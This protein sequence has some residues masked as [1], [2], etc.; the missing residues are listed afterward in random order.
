MKFLIDNN[1][2]EVHRRLAEYPQFVMGQLRTPR[3]KTSFA[4]GRTFAIDNGAFIGFAERKFR[5]LLE[6][7]RPERDACLFVVAPDIPMNARRTL[8]C[9]D[10]WGDEL[11]GWPIALAAQNGQEDLSIPWK[12]ID[13][14]FIGGDDRF[15]DSQS[16]LDIC[17]AGRILGKHVHVGRV[18][19]ITRF[20]FFASHADTCDG[21]GAS[22]FDWMIDAI[23]DGENDDRPLLVTP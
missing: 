14:I 20:R 6:R 10:Y 3:S 18:N 22:R 1:E 11:M 19:S 15:K 12:S 17:K 9:L 16:A 7:C 4:V 21:S 13:A 2:A 23:A 5:H 8:E